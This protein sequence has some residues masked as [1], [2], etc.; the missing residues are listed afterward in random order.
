MLNPGLNINKVFIEQ[1]KIHM[2]LTFSSKTM[3]P[4]RIVLRKDNN[5]VLSLFMFDENRKNII[6]KVISSVVYYIIKNNVCADY[7]CCP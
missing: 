6:F 4:I 7:L 1:L 5:R 2:D 3:I